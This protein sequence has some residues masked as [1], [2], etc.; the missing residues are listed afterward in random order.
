MKTKTNSLEE[1][2]KYYDDT[3]R[4]EW[5][6]RIAIHKYDQEHWFEYGQKCL[7]NYYD[8]YHPFDQSQTLGIEKN[9]KMQWGEYEITGYIDRLARHAD[10]V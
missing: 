3:W 5:H 6:D 7:K 1:L 2:L 4:V 8:K 10:G 9:I